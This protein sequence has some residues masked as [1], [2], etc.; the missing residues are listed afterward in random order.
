M[1]ADTLFNTLLNDTEALLVPFSV[2]KS[3]TVSNNATRVTESKKL[4]CKNF[5]IYFPSYFAWLEIDF[6][7]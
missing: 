2:I 4:S 1:G 7:G 5:T 3:G 6:S